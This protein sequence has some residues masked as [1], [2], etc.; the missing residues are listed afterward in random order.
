MLR[1]SSLPVAARPRAFDQ[2]AEASEPVRES[3][4]TA[5]I[6]EGSEPTEFVK[7]VPGLD[8]IVEPLDAPRP[9]VNS[10]QRDPFVFD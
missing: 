1:Y 10:P 4:A 6:G 9:V 5:L 3:V 8:R 2:T 7:L